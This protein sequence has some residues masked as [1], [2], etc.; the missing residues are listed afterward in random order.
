MA[1][2]LISKA[3]GDIFCVKGIIAIAAAMLKILY[4]RNGFN[5][6]KVGVTELTGSGYINIIKKAA[7]V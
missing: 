6:V 4:I 3:A 1:V 5:I 2:L 7:K